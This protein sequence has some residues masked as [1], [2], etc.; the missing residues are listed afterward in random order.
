MI[1]ETRLTAF[2]LSTKSSAIAEKVIITQ[3][4]ITNNSLQVS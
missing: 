1:N 4:H 2:I 3:Y